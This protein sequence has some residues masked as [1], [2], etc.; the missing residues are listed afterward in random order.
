MADDL[1]AEVKGEG[2]TLDIDKAFERLET[3]GEEPSETSAEKPEEKPQTLLK[4]VASGQ[5]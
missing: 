2:A 1:F 5:K 4:T 3:K